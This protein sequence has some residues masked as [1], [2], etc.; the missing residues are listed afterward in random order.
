L[1][2]TGPI[3]TE[4]QALATRTLMRFVRGWTRWT[5]KLDAHRPD[6]V[7]ERAAKQE[8]TNYAMSEMSYEFVKPA[9]MLRDGAGIAGHA[10]LP[11]G[12]LAVHVRSR[13][14]PAGHV[15]LLLHRHQPHHRYLCAGHAGDR[16]RHCL[17]LL[18]ARSAF[19][20]AFRAL[21]R[22]RR[23]DAAGGHDRGDLVPVASDQP[24]GAS[25][26]QHAGRSHHAESVRRLRRLARQPGRAR[27]RRR[28]SA[29]AS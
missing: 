6:P 20:Q 8:R 15:P 10:L 21:G 9:S 29:A 1:W 24:V 16:H 27:H 5:A 12:V 25:V 3:P 19:P 17:R 7:D 18:E 4:H 14:E 26:R 11:D 28:N 23:A 22:S 2:P 13:G